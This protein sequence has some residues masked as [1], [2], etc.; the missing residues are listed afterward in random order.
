M[1]KQNVKAELSQ[2]VALAKEEK[3]LEDELSRLKERR[4]DAGHILTDSV[5][6]SMDIFPYTLRTFS[7]SG[8]SDDDIGAKE[9]IRK[10]IQKAR[11]QLV[12]KKKECAKA[13]RKVNEIIMG[14]K[15][16]EMRQILTLK[17]I[18]GKGWNGIA[19][20]I[21]GKATADSVRVKHDRFLKNL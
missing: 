9:A 1:M 8:L 15:D 12:R 4:R 14:I 5:R 3:L 20:H 7:V 21:G 10:D 13:Y 19:Q 11:I 6:G 2:F 17:Y 18:Y 16:S